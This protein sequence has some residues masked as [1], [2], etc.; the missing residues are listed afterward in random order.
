[1]RLAIHDETIDG[2]PNAPAEQPG[3]GGALAYR[4]TV[5]NCF[6]A[7][8]QL[9]GIL[10]LSFVLIGNDGKRRKNETDHAAAI[11]ESQKRQLVNQ[12]DIFLGQQRILNQLKEA[13]DGK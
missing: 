11:E 8:A 9:I 5:A 7:A 1:M 6:M 13:R 3:N 4:I 10:Y 2:E 12:A